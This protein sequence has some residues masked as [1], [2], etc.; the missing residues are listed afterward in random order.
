MM[1]MMMMCVEVRSRVVCFF[2][3][4]FAINVIL[5]LLHHQSQ[6]HVHVHVVVVVFVAAAA[7]VVVVA[8]VV[9]AA[10][11]AVVFVAALAVVIDDLVEIVEYQVIVGG[12]QEYMLHNNLTPHNTHTYGVL[13]NLHMQWHALGDDIVVCIECWLSQWVVVVWG[14]RGQVGGG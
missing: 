2:N 12:I 5:Y 10:V 1:M 13:G 3:V 9:A 11:V 7:V 8:A 6:G 4:F 14:Q